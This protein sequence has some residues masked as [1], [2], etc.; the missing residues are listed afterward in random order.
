MICEQG[1]IGGLSL[2]IGGPEGLI[3]GVLGDEAVRDAVRMM[4]ITRPP[5]FARSGHHMGPDRV[6][7]NR[8]NGVRL[9]L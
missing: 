9:D 6:Q 5:V 8:K 3:Q 4:A 1:S 7:F 2:M